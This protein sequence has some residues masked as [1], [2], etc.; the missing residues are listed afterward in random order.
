MAQTI[1]PDALADEGAA[2]KAVANFDPSKQKA[3]ESLTSA[4]GERPGYISV[5]NSL[6]RGGQV[7]AIGCSA[8]R[9]E[10][11][12]P[13]RSNAFEFDATHLKKLQRRSLPIWTSWLPP[14][15]W[16]KDWRLS[17]GP[18]ES[19]MTTNKS[20]RPASAFR[21]RRIGNCCFGS[22]LA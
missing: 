4:A 5:P 8:R 2:A 18:S 3:I 19:T 11:A 7:S 10:K 1:I 17:Q 13:T 20:R 15:A 21:C 6:W 16:V 22:R 14:E 9:G 12:R